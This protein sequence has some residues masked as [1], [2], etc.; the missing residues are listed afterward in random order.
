MSAKGNASAGSEIAR[1]EAYC[2]QLEDAIDELEHEARR[3]RDKLE[4]AGGHTHAISRE[5]E[6]LK[7]NSA[8][9]RKELAAARRRVDALKSSSG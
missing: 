1:L 5:L 4:R 7:R 6:R 2:E 3:C 8:H 9:N